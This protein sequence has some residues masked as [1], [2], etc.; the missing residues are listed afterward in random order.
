MAGGAGPYSTYAG[1]QVADYK[2]AAFYQKEERQRFVYPM[3]DVMSRKMYILLTLVPAV[4]FLL[5]GLFDKGMDAWHGTLSWY[6]VL[7]NLV[8]IVPVIFRRATVHLFLGILFTLLWG[9][10]LVTGSMILSPGNNPEHLAQWKVVG[11]TIFLIF[12]FLC[13]VCLMMGGVLRLGDEAQ[14]RQ[15]TAG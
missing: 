5:L 8:F 7:F 11:M 2:T 6:H 9:Y 15:Q 12:S 4:Y 10:L 1:R 3:N 13:S 14:R